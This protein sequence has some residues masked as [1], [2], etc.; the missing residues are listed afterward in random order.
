MRSTPTG[1]VF[2]DAYVDNVYAVPVDGKPKVAV[3]VKNADCAVASPDGTR[4]ALERCSKDKNEAVIDF[5]LFV[6]DVDGS[7]EHAVVSGPTSD[8]NPRWSP[9]GRRVAFDRYVSGV[10][11]VIGIANAAGSGAH[12]L[13][14]GEVATFQW[15]PDGKRM[16]Y[17]HEIGVHEPWANPRER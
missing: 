13:P 5:D 15:A 14:T 6:A 9:A 1:S 12:I 17:E 3:L 8:T 4:L 10:R 2:F 11:D 7:H 16:S